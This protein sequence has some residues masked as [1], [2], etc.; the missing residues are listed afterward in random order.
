MW[1]RPN[2]KVFNQ[3][4]LILLKKYLPPEAAAEEVKFIEKTLKLKPKM[5][6]LDLACGWGRHSIEL[7]LRGYEVTGLDL[8]PLYLK[9]GKKSAEKL[10]LKIRWIKGDMRKISFKNE[11][12][13]ILSLS[14]SFG[15]FEKED[16]HQKVIFEV[17][18]ALKPKGFF[19]LDVETLELFAYHYKAEQKKK[20]AK[21]HFL[22]I[23]S[24]F[25][26]LR[27]RYEEE[28]IEF[29]KNK[30]KEKTFYSIRAFTTKELISLCQKA[31]L[32]FKKVYG[33]FKD[34]P[35]SFNSERCILIT[36]KE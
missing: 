11:F 34:K 29:W 4:F 1:Y 31:G 9:E 14:N 23:K 35:L 22:I 26:F 12:D 27:S 28:I 16:D 13:V 36:Q 18:K 5:K 24:S 10:N 32:K 19:F 30:K 25:D 3:R 7:A 8:N 6:I 17:A 33:G 21:D 15:Y 2:G 20:L